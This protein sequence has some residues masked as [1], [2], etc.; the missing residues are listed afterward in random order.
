MELEIKEQKEN[1]LLKRKEVEGT[2]KFKGA[3]PK[4]EQVAA[5]IAKKVGGQAE[6]VATKGIETKFGKQ[7]AT[8]K[9]YIYSDKDSMMK[10]EPKKK[11]KEE[12]AQ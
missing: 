4:G 3:T 9:A 10:I 1:P 7:E 2:I 6:L 8:F 11:V 12:K 5:E